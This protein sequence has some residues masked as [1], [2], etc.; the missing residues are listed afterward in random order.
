[1]SAVRV[2]VVPDRYAG[3]LT[4]AQAAEAIAAGWPAGGSRHDRVVARPTS[5]GGLGL[6]EAVEAA[7]DGTTEM[8]VV[9][10]P[11][12][13]PVPAT[14]LLTGEGPRTAYLEAAQ[15]C[16]EQVRRP[17]DDP[18][19]ASSRGLGELVLAAHALGPDRIVIGLTGAAVLDAGLGL[20][21]ALL[22]GEHTQLGGGVGALGELVADEVIGV[23]EA[24]AVLR[25]VELVG[26]GDLGQPLLGLA[27]VAATH[28]TELG[29]EPAQAQ[30]AEGALGHAVALVRAELGEPTDLLTGLPLRL[31]RTPGAG[32]GAGLG[33]GLAV[34]GARLVDGPALALE[35]A[36]ILDQVARADLVV[37][38]CAV[39]GAAAL[40]GSVVTALSA[41]A[42]AHGIPVV[43]IAG[44]VEAGRRET[45]AAG[46]SGAY[47]VADSLAQWPG[48]VANPLER[49]TARAEA[50][51]RTWS[52]RT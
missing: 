12:G 32:A 19:A 25:G 30:H 23:R 37:T 26:A 49:L 44:R 28:G 8:V 2:L 34:L 33:F 35:E 5:D 3:L 11:W 21:A 20:V 41:A 31:D 9:A 43:V 45:M 42:G 38:G 4:S 10:D 13:R 48:F 39:L 29:L 47:A 6:L 52:P 1:M 16:G 24:S 14:I 40:H 36:G 22:P 15:V 7:R 17:G 18:L 50:V 51:A 46:L 27:G